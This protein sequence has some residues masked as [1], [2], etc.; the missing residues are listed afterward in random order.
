MKHSRLVKQMVRQLV[1]LA[2]SLS[3][4][5][6]LAEHIVG[7][8]VLEA[9]HIVPCCRTRE[10]GTHYTSPILK[11]FGLRLARLEGPYALHTLANC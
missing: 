8:D 2:G 3:T 5:A 7:A 1:H 11:L 6:L 9:F 10:R 4:V